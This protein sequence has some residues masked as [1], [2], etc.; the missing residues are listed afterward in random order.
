MGLE[1]E[2]ILYTMQLNV[3]HAKTGVS[4]NDCMALALARQE[5]CSLLPCDGA[6][7]QIALGE[8][9]EVRGTLWLVEE[10]FNAGLVDLPRIREAY[11]AMKADVLKTAAG[12]F[13]P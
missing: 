10:M 6:L 7:R 9:V 12:W 8:G 11:A 5:N 3:K 1:S 4:S 2:A 13:S